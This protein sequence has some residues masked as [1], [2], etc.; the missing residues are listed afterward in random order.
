LASGT[1]FV[2]LQRLTDTVLIT[3]EDDGAGFDAAAA[4]R[5]SERRGLGLVGI[6]RVEQLRGTHR[7]ESAVGQGTRLSC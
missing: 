1:A 2:Y 4:E 6:Q 3:I 5:A 7:L